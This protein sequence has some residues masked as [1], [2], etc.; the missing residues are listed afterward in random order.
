MTEQERAR[1]YHC[2]PDQLLPKGKTCSD[3]IRFLSCAGFL[4]ENIR[5]NRHCDWS[6]SYFRDRVMHGSGEATR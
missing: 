5:D 2:E 1:V 6:P 4:G 3:C